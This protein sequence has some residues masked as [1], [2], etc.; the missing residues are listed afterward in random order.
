[1]SEK[2]IKNAG[3]PRNTQPD[4]SKKTAE[5]TGKAVS[6]PRKLLGQVREALHTKHRGAAPC[7]AAPIV[8]KK[9]M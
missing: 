3:S 5:L 1:M 2:D 4:G 6:K 7:G 9:S 8:P